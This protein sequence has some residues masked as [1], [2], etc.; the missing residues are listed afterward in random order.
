MDW[1]SHLTDAPFANILF[2]AGLAF[3]A[4][5]IIGRIAGKIEP[6]RGGRLMSEIAGVVS[7]LWA[8]ISTQILIARSSSSAMTRTVL[9]VR[10]CR[11]HL[12]RRRWPI[13]HSRK[14]VRAARTVK[15]RN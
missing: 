9:R 7:F 4:I 12:R 11:G 6:D 10:I 1:L 8:A 3:L 2:L 15:S 5:G 14:L 13:T